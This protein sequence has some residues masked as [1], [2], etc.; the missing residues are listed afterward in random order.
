[1]LA[2]TGALT[3]PALYP[4]D[5]STGTDSDTGATNSSEQVPTASASAISTKRPAIHARLGPS[6]DG[7]A[8]FCWSEFEDEHNKRGGRFFHV[9]HPECF[10]FA[11]EILP[12]PSMVPLQTF[13]PPV[14]ISPPPPTSP[15]VTPHAVQRVKKGSK[16]IA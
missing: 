14:P 8:P 3:N 11:W 4:S 1:M 5:P 9:G 13:R 6:P 15:V 2:A 12:P 16:T 7:H 10:D